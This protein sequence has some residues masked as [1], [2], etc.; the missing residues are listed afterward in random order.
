MTD[1]IDELLTWL[2]AYPPRSTARRRRTMGDLTPK[3][4]ALRA[5]ANDAVDYANTVDGW[6]IYH[7]EELQLAR[8]VLLLL[9]VSE[10]VVRDC[11]ASTGLY[12]PYAD[13]LDALERGLTE[14]K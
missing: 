7:A 2:E 3:L 13:L 8:A 6:A 5:R 1:P 14:G 4:A 11:T 9:D 12:G 10:A